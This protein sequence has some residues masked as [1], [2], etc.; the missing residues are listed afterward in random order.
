[1]RTSIDV[2]VVGSGPAGV[3]AAFP[4]V[5]AGLRVLM[6]DG[7]EMPSFGVPD[8]EYLSV[9]AQDPRQWEWMLGRDFHALR[10]PTSLS[11]KFRVATLEYVFRGFGE[12][13]RI[14]VQGFAPFGSLAV[15]GLSNAW[16]A[17]VARFG[18][19]DLTDFPFGGNALLPSFEAVARR[20]GIS[21]R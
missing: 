17:G 18:D 5:D 19:D 7:G 20:I 15:G 8:A 16:G 11:A 9:R 4:L 6:V 12:R 10:G 21:G 1:E 3:S 14:D 13:N 2:I